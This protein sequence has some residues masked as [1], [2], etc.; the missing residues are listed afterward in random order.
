[1]FDCLDEY[2]ELIDTYI[3]YSEKDGKID[4]KILGGKEEGLNELALLINTF[5]KVNLDDLLKEI[6]EYKGIKTTYMGTTNECERIIGRSSLYSDIIILYDDLYTVMKTAYFEDLARM[7]GAVFVKSLREI[8]ALKEWIKNKI[9]VLVPRYS[10]WNDNNLMQVGH[11]TVEDTKNPEYLK[12]F[13]SLSDE[14]KSPLFS[15]E[16]IKLNA[17]VEGKEVEKHVSDSLA[18]TLNEE[19]C[20]LGALNSYSVSD[21]QYQWRKMMFKIKSETNLFKKNELIPQSLST[22]NLDFLDGI[23]ADLDRKSTRLNSSHIPLS[24]MPS[25]A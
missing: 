4:I 8:I 10:L 24:R 16:E 9:V 3:K 14:D 15:D 12:W 25:S 1:M 11:L 23:T 17:G 19:H 20:F 2:L 22:I 18:L 5:W 21:S 7:E 13:E 6:S